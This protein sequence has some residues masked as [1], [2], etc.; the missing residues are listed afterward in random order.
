MIVPKI[1]QL[2]YRVLAPAGH[3]DK[4]FHCC[5]IA[6]SYSDALDHLQ[7]MVSVKAL[8]LYGKPQRVELDIETRTMVAQLDS[9]TP[10]CLEVICHGK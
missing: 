5:I 2:Q 7:K 1:F 6:D 10:S 3:F 9:I 8:G 4:D